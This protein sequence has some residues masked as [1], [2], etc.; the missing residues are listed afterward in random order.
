MRITLCSVASDT[1]GVTVEAL[2]PLPIATDIPHARLLLDGAVAQPLPGDGWDDYAKPFRT[3]EDVH[4]L[5][6]LSAWLYGVGL[7][8]RWPQ[9]L[10][11]KL[12]GVLAAG[13][14]VARSIR[15]RQQRICCWAG[16]LRSSNPCRPNWTLPWKV[17]VNGPCSG[18]ATADC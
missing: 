11:L 16:C 12:A 9:A 4:V 1:S 10:R 5:L 8:C 6:A 2:P 15:V 17:P 7:E 13:S 14:E 18:G 3:L